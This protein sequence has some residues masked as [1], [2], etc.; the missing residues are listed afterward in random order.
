MPQKTSSPAPATAWQPQWRTETF[1]EL[2]RPLAKVVGAKTA[3]ALESL[4]L[5]TVGDLVRHLPRRY[6]SGTENS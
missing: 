1:A 5:H 3:K 6:L 2:N 4:R